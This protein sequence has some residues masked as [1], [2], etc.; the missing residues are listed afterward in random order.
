MLYMMVVQWIVLLEYLGIAN[1]CMPVCSNI[2]TLNYDT[3]GH[4][5]SNS[6]GIIYI[7]IYYI[8]IYIYIY[9]YYIY[10]YLNFCYSLKSDVTGSLITLLIV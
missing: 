8:Y 6:I 4:A 9:I 10:K 2:A 5:N 1:N 3:C 7:Y